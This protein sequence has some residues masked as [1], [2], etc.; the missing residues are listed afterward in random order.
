MV[1]GGTPTGPNPVDRGKKGSK[2]HV[3]TDA[4][5][6]PLVVA[7]SAANV[8]DGDRVLEPRVHPRPAHRRVVDR[9]PVQ[10]LDPDGVVVHARGGDEQRDQRPRLFLPASR[11]VM[12]AGT[13]AAACTVWESIATALGAPRRVRRPPA[14]AES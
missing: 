7:V 12:S 9:D 4:A 13:L 2:L 10:Q 6:L 1:V 3:L 11:P 5:G 14:P 8:H